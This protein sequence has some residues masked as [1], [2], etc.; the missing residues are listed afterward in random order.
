MSHGKNRGEEV[1]TNESIIVT[2]YDS[3]EKCTTFTLKL[4]DDFVGQLLGR[5]MQGKE[6]AGVM[7]GNKL[8]IRSS[9]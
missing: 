9:S 5:V 6:R 4:N 1:P 8:A 7:P 2:G 3:A